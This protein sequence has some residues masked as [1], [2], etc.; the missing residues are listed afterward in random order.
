[1]DLV[2]E[3]ILSVKL[4]LS[5]PKKKNKKEETFEGKFYTTMT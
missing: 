3:K 5:Y 2:N 4:E 1:M